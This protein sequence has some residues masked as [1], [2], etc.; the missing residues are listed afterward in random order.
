MFSIRETDLSE[1]GLL[2]KCLS[3]VSHHSSSGRTKINSKHGN[4]RFKSL[5]SR[6]GRF[7]NRDPR[8]ED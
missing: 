8:K 1:D 2:I 3:C 7:T 4:P 5:S 6:E